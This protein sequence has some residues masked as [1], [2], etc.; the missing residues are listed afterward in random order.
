MIELRKP[1]EKL[2]KLIKKAVS[3]AVERETYDWPPQCAFL[4]YQ[5]KRP[6]GMQ[7]NR[8]SK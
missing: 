1:N 3:A 5:P 7:K 6:V 8:K 2:N 4:L